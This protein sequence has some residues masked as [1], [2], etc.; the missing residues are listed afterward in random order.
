MAG[1]S[2]TAQELPPWGELRASALKGVKAD[3]AT[4]LRK[5][6][7]ICLTPREPAAV[8]RDG[9]LLTA[10]L[11]TKPTV[12]LRDKLFFVIDAD[13]TGQP[14][15]HR[16][17]ATYARY[18]A[19]QLNLRLSK[20]TLA[21]LRDVHSVRVFYVEDIKLKLKRALE[22]LLRRAPAGRA[23]TQLWDASSHALLDP[24]PD[25][26]TAF[27]L[28]ESQEAA[29]AAMTSPGG[30]FVWGPPGTGKTTVITE[31]VRRM[32]A[33]DCSV[34]IASHT[35]VAVDNV[36]EG[37]ADPTT[38]VDFECGDVI[39]VASSRTRDRVSAVVREHGHLLV[40]DAAAVLNKTV[41]RRE[42]LQ[43]RLDANAAD[44][45]RLE[46]DALDDALLGADA[47][48]IERARRAVAA[49]DKVA[50][51]EQQRRAIDA[52]I[53][54]LDAKIEWCARAAASLDVT[55]AEQVAASDKVQ[56]SE[57]AFT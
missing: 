35:H 25:Q 11:S 26:P 17:P 31:A 45:A 47:V 36:L 6:T 43:R 40:D 33:E 21:E 23:V 7:G 15:E 14:S 53:S 4:I 20:E 48:A 28:H 37:V 10:T 5:G 49:R 32:L 54:E 42:A 55:E 50:E 16:H 2:Q 19:N 24:L 41:E 51:Y 39:R 9:D 34:L 52:G 12:R 22:D 1:R 27:P 38:G 13:L 56:H 30:W 57:L 46:R 3:I 18:R 44:E 29:L 8:P